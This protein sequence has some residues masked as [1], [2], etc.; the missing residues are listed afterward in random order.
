V[1]NSA[2]TGTDSIVAPGD[3]LAIINWI[4]AH[5][6]QTEGQGGTADRGQESG[7]RSQEEDLLLMLA[8]DV[9]GQPRRGRVV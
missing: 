2:G 6:G 8:M 1:T 4:N 5:P 7:D 9:A 3:A